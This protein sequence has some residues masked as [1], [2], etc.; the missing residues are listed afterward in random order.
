MTDDGFAAWLRRN[1]PPD[2]QVLVERFGGYDKIPSEAWAEFD[3]AMAAWHERR[4]T[5]AEAGPASDPEAVCLC[6]RAG[7]YWRPRKGGGRPIWRCEQHR[8]SW[9]DYAIEAPDDVVAQG[10]RAGAVP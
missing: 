5:R 7:I 10:R 8:N 1:P 4:R 9:P 2:L 3:R 6:G